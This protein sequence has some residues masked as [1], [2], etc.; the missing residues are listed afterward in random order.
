M[1]LTR[2]LWSNCKTNNHRR[3]IYS[4]I[5]KYIIKKAINAW[6]KKYKFKISKIIH[7]LNMKKLL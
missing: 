7:D 6:E 2:E 4:W 5:Q 1:T 3:S